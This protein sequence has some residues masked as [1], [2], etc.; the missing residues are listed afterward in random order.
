MARRLRD[1]LAPVPYRV[2]AGEHEEPDAPPGGG[3]LAVIG[4]SGAP[5]RAGQPGAQG[6]HGPGT[7]ADGGPGGDAGRAEGGQDAGRVHVV[8]RPGDAADTVLIAARVVTAA[9]RREDG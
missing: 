6:Y 2:S 7:G 5:G 4:A 3:P 9:G 8:L 1:R